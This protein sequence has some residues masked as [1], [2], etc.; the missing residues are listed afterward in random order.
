MDITLTNQPVDII[1]AHAE[2]DASK[3]YTIQ[4][5]P[6]FGD[7]V[8]VHDG[9]TMPAPRTG[10]K[11]RNLETIRAKAGTAGRLWLWAPTKSDAAAVIVN[12][13]EDI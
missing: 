3:V 5:D 11:V 12:I 2:L 13:F 4:A 6:S 9:D 10:R 1:A 8:H 7:L